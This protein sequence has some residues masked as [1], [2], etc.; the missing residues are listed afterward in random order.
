MSGPRNPHGEVFATPFRT[1]NL[2]RLTQPVINFLSEEDGP[3]AVEY[4][5]ILAMIVIGCIGA[6]SF[7]AGKTKESFDTSGAAISGAFN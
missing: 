7:L 6:V 1:M 3:T 2:Q 5:V 4:A